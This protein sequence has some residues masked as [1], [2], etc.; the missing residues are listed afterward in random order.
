MS[1]RAGIFLLALG[2]CAPWA[3]AQP[4]DAE[5]PKTVAKKKKVPLT[6]EQAAQRYKD[7]LAHEKAG[8]D[9]PALKA[10][11]DAGEAGHGQAQKRLSEIYDR[12]NSAT[13][14]DY[15]TSVIW[16]DKARAQGVQ[17]PKPLTPIRGR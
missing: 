2:V 9:K 14:R 5:K 17:F 10:F 15:E 6:K 4:T 11:L 1:F 13:K 16:Y 8:S 7:G 12:G 3:M